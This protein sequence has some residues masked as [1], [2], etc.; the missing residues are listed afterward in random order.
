MLREVDDKL[1][2]MMRRAA[3]L[4]FSV[5]LLGSILACRDK[6]RDKADSAGAS[7]PPVYP[8]SPLGNTGWNVDAGPVMI[9][10]VGSGGDSIAVVLPEATDSTVALIQGI[11]PPISGLTFDLF[12]RGGRTGSSAVSPLPLLPVDTTRECYSWPLGKLQAPH[13]N[14]RVGFATGRVHAIMLDS[15]EALPSADSA[16]LAASLAQTAAT[17][18]IASDPTFRGLPFR[19]RSAFTFQLNSVD[20]VIADVVRSVNEEANPRLEHLL[21]IGE[22]PAGTKG[23]FNLGYYSRTAGAEESTQATEV[24][25]AVQ[26]GPAKRPAFVVNIEYDDGGKL[27][28]VERIG[29]GEWRTMWR[30]AYTDC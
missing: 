10:S 5:M 17:L 13:S 29:P 1:L 20:V 4:V 9:V 12:G 24:L 16:A 11:S 30:S 7:L 27:G 2:R 8:P 15:I 22:R 23:K 26:I 6:G 25:A 19:V 14:W 18:P 28:L 3:G 21:M